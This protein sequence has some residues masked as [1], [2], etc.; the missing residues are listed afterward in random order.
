MSLVEASEYL[1]AKTYPIVQLAKPF[2]DERGSIQNLTTTGA[3]SVAIIQSKAGS[4]RA[5]HVHKTDD[6]LAF[7]ISG[8]IEYWWQDVRLTPSGEVSERFDEVK[9]VLIEAG[10]AF[11]TPRNV[12]HTMYFP[13]DTVFA[14]LSCQSRAHADHEADL[15][16]VPSL[17]DAGR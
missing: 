4:S 2:L 15:V 17:K 14:T 1:S 16:R 13:E 3:R 10:Q 7:V 8:R 6:H 9:S 5:S 12:A 11:Y